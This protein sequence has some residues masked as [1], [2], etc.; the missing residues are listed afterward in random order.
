MARE[1]ETEDAADA[2]RVFTF[3]GQAVVLDSDVADRFGT[4][5]GRLNEQVKRNANRFGDDFAFQLDDDETASLKSQIA[6]ANGTGR[7][8]R[9]GRPWMFTEHGVVMAATV[10]KTETAARAAQEIVRS[11]V[12]QRRLERALPD[13]TNLPA[14]ASQQS[15]ALTVARPAL[16]QKI[17]AAVGRVLDAIVDPGAGSTV[18]EEARTVALEGLDAFKAHLRKQ[19]VKNEEILAQIQKL[20][21]E[22]EQIDAEIEGKHIDNE[23]RRLALVAKQLRIVLELERYS[24]TGDTD[25][26]RQTLAD[27]AR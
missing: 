15:A 1:D 3:R 9:R 10:L 8:G 26:L 4:R 19:G 27:I 18:R 5:T 22:A 24:L 23:H 17:D 16:I 7:G 25:S 14:I 12:A 6:T 2:I 11:F 20:L 21:K 13:G